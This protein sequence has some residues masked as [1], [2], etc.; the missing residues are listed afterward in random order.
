MI[1]PR[2]RRLLLSLTA[3]LALVLGLAVVIQ[4]ADVP[5]GDEARTPAVVSTPAPPPSR[6]PDRTPA[7]LVLSASTASAPE[8]GL[9]AERRIWERRV[10]RARHTLDSYLAATRYPPT[11]RP[12]REHPDR[13]HPAE[14]ERDVPL[15]PEGDGEVRLLL[16]QEKVYVVGDESVGFS[17][18]CVDPEGAV[19]ACEVDAAFAREAE[20]RSQ[21]GAPS[22]VPLEF[23][24]DGTGTLSA[25]LQP[26]RDGFALYEGTIRVHLT[27]RSEETERR[28]FFDVS[29]TPAAPAAFSGR[30]REVMEDGSLNLYLGMKVRKAGRYVVTGRIDDANGKPFALVT[31]NEELTPGMR[32]AK[33]TVF[34]KLVL[35]EDPEQPLVL[36]DVEGF[37]LRETGDPDREL[38]R[39]LSGRVHR[40]EAHP[41]SRFSSEEWQSEE[42]ERHV[43]EFTRDFERAREGAANFPP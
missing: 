10:E 3:V 22:P 14:P 12:I 27:V 4:R 23:K 7:P 13:I 29:Y 25:R 24:D 42:R 28:V 1:R 16:R 35:D 26:S 30:V 39:A 40:C 32:E 9:E 20:H 38:M 2:L 33:L 19:R 6:A 5:T 31:F 41:A 34:G 21:A 17:I 43:K 8:E 11:S 37:L 18:R 15:D 36:R